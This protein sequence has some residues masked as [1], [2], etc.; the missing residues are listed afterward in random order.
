MDL[1]EQIELVKKALN[2]TNSDLGAVLNK[3]G[4]TF[5]KSLKRRSLSDFEIQELAK[6]IIKMRLDDTPEKNELV[7]GLNNGIRTKILK[8]KSLILDKILPIE[9]EE[10]LKNEIKGDPAYFDLNFRKP[11]EITENNNSL[12]EEG[13]KYESGKDCGYLKELCETQKLTI[14]L[15]KNENERLKN[16]SKNFQKDRKPSNGT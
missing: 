3:N 1:Y 10:K 12:K 14:E 7:K 8:K 4:D 11:I 16:E 6:A 2:L 15:L 13:E 9:E 5:R